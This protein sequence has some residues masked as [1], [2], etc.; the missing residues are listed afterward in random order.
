MI[1]SDMRKGVGGCEIY[2]ELCLILT[3]VHI[4]TVYFEPEI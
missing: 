1:I 3:P 2:K 4:K